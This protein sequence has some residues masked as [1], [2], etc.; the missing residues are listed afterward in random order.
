MTDRLTLYLSMVQNQETV[1]L[2]LFVLIAG[3]MGVWSVM[4]ASPIRFVRWMSRWP[5]W[6][7]IL[8]LYLTFF[9]CIAFLW[10]NR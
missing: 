3:L 8:A 5:F 10:P 4:D 6:S 7:F 9:Y 1:T 2:G